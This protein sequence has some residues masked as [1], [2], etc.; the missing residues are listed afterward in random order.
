MTNQINSII[1]IKQLLYRMLCHDSIGKIIRAK[2]NNRIPSRG[3]QIDVRDSAILS[4]TVAKIYWNIYERAEANFVNKYLPSSLD[5]IELG[6]SIGVVSSC[7]GKQ[8]DHD[9]VRLICVEANPQLIHVLERNLKINANS[10]EHYVIN[11]AIDYSGKNEV[12]LEIGERTTDSKVTD[13][14]FGSIVPALTLAQL[15]NQFDVKEFCLVADIEGKEWELL[16]SETELMR[17][18]QMIIMEI[19]SEFLNGTQLPSEMLANDIVG[20]LGYTVIDRRGDVF[21]FSRQSQSA[22]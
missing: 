7:I 16:Y 9:G 6:S 19:H 3:C 11:A 20:K 2:Y 15:C 22:E 18:C 13:S 10:V 21:V 5:V 14:H 4:P 17:K 8:L 12:S 1:K